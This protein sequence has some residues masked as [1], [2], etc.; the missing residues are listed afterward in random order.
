MKKVKSMFAL[1]LALLMLA[2]CVVTASATDAAEEPNGDCSTAMA[3]TVGSK[4]KGTLQDVND[5]DYFSFV[6]GKTGLAT[7][8]IAHNAIVGA[9]ENAS[10]FKVTVLRLVDGA[11]KA[12]AT[13]TSNGT[14][15]SDTSTAFS[16]N[17][18]GTYYVRVEAGIVF[19]GALDYTVTANVNT[20]VLA[21]KE[22]NNDKSYAT[23]LE[24]STSG[25]AKHYYGAISKNDVDF[26]SFSL[27]APGVVYVY[28]Y[29]DA[30]SA[31]NY[32]VTLYTYVEVEDGT[33]QLAEISSATI[34]PNESSVMTAGIG[35]N[36]GNY[37]IAVKGVDGSEGGYRTR[38]FYTKVDNA[39]YEI[40]DDKT[41]A[42]V[43]AVNTVKQATIDA[44]NDVDYFKVTVP[45]S[46]NGYEV[47]FSL[48]SKAAEKAGQWKLSVANSANKTIIKETIISNTEK[49][50]FETE[51]LTAGT[52]YIKVTG[53]ATLNTGIY[54]IKVTPKT[55][56]V[57]TPEEPE[58]TLWERIMALDWDGFMD[59]FNGWFEQ[60]DIEAII[61]S[62]TASI[63]TVFTYLAS[64]G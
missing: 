27:S 10:Y 14:S 33:S 5:K 35:L 60:I 23:A 25:K 40:N 59:N 52:Y 19:N 13:F 20:D 2:S 57:E 47:S 15:T 32:I 46:N 31:G 62:I 8:T 64:M 37:L 36:G 44:E 6:P 26:Y 22:P 63:V 7:V 48:D 39:E 49:G 17:A 58:L 11:E 50:E 29:N 34:T 56:T 61:N 9:A 1:L 24:C 28:L 45:A 3:M 18:N 51:A 41:M 30:T 43:L 53:G 16:V 38:V 4:S 21:E 54:R 12:V 42:N 55:A